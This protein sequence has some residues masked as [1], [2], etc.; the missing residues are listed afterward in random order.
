MLLSRHPSIPRRPSPHPNE[1][2]TAGNSLKQ[3]QPATGTLSRA[4]PVV[5]LLPEQAGLSP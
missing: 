5:R 3:G 1:H 4:A 2:R